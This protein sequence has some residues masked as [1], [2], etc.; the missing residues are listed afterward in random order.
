MILTQ[1]CIG[2]IFRLPLGVRLK[3]MHTN[4]PAFENTLGVQGLPCLL[5][6]SQGKPRTPASLLIAPDVPSLRSA[7][8]AIDALRFSVYPSTALS[9]QHP[10][11][12]P[13]SIPFVKR[14]TI[15]IGDYN[16]IAD[17][18]LTAFSYSN[19]FYKYKPGLLAMY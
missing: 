6:P 10:R 3:V 7:S 14:A 13:T 18:S 9:N 1:K 17:V 16:C 11:R 4:R 2:C 15:R 5:A 8:V 19:S 12:N